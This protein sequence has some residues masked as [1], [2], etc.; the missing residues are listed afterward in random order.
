MLSALEHLP[1]WLPIAG[2]FTNAA[3]LLQTG[4]IGN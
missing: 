1:L 4:T 2:G 3:P